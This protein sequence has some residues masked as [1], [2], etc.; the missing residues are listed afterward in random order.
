M[1]C[2]VCMED[3]KPENLVALACGHIYHTNCVIRLVETRTRK[4]PLCRIRI[5]WH[6]KQLV[7][8]RVLSVNS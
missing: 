6:K 1:N 4:C 2:V 5:T 8:H 7:K 3:I